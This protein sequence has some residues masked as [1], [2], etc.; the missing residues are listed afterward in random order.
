MTAPFPQSEPP[1]IGGFEF[2]PLFE[3]AGPPFQRDIAPEQR[4]RSIQVRLGQKEEFR[5]TFK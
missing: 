5:V 4:M 3:P 1:T 2:P